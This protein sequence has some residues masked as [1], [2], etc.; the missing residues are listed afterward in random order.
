MKFLMVF[1]NFIFVVCGIGLMTAGGIAQAQYHKWYSFF[2]GDTVSGPALV[3]VVGVFIFLVAFFGCCG[4]Y[5]ESY[6]M[7]MTYSGIVGVIMV[8]QF[9]GGIAAL[10]EKNEIENY[11]TPDLKNYVEQYFSN[12]TSK[13]IKEL[14]D[15]LQKDYT[16]CGSANFTDYKG[17]KPDNVT[18]LIPQS[19]C[20]DAKVCEMTDAAIKKCTPGTINKDCIIFE[21]GCQPELSDLLEFTINA[22]GGAAIGL[23]FLELIGVFFACYLA[24]SIRSGYV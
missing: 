10:V 13:D 20:K 19:C 2:N 7:L 5:Q 9:A 8:L 24:R 18:R 23:A 3:I 22:A 21:K 15:Q 16:C 1:F 11:V 6:C 4:A 12:T 14:V 17:L